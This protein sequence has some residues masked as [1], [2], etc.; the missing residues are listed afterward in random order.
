MNSTC[1]MIAYQIAFM[2]TVLDHI[3]YLTI[4]TG[5]DANAG[6]AANAFAIISGENGNTK[7]IELKKNQGNIVIPPFKSG[8]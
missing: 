1:V 3:Y 6:T 8:R 5:H 2:V 7:E 4:F